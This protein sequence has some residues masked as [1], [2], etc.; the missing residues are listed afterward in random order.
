MGGDR[1]PLVRL[2][3]PTFRGWVDGWVGGLQTGGYVGGG[4]EPL[5]H[6]QAGRSDLRLADGWVDMGRRPP[7]VRLENG[8][9]DMGG[10]T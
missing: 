9:V 7:L 5:A 1:P 6:G 3:A 2:I 4:Q 8:W 10:W